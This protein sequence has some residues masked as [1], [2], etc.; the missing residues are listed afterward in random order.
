[1]TLEDIKNKVRA[2]MNEVSSDEEL[3][4]LSED[5]IKLDEYI[6]SCI[7]DAINLII[8]VAPIRCINAIKAVVSTEDGIIPLPVDFLRPVSIKLSNWNR[9]VSVIFP[10]ESEQYKI[11]HN[12]ITRAGV[13]KPVCVFGYN[14]SG[15]VVECYPSGRVE[16]FYYAK[17]VS[18]EIDFNT[19]NEELFGSICYMCA[20]LVY[21]IF[22]NFKTGEQMKNTASE[23]MPKI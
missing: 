5:T 4:L 15:N 23:L 22:E 21:N 18:K 7:P 1:M 3:H 19:F 20:S 8:S 16:F 11:Q 14:V 10:Y 17:A 9:S 13:N 12:L 2:I 6:K